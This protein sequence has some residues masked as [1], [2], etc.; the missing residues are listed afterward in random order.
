[1]AAISIL[2]QVTSMVVGMGRSTLR[3]WRRPR[4]ALRIQQEI[5][6]TKARSLIARLERDKIILGVWNEIVLERLRGFE[7]RADITNRYLA[8]IEANAAAFNAAV[9]E[10]YE[11]LQRLEALNQAIAEAIAAHNQEIEAQLAAAAALEAKNL[12]KLEGLEV[13]PPTATPTPTGN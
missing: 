5:E 2:T 4:E 7:E 9:R 11:E 8:E 12:E 3:D 13:A 6:L 10:K 1:M